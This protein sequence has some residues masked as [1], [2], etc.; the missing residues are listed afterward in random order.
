VGILFRA[1]LSAVAVAFLWSA[2]AVAA[3]PVKIK[4]PWAVTPAHLTPLLFHDK[5]KLKHN[6]KSYDVEVLFLRGSGENVTALAADEIQIAAVNFQTLH[7]LIHRA[8]LDVR[9]I[10]DVF[11]TRKGKA[12]G[13]FYVDGNKIKTI[14]D[15]KGKR[16]A[17]NARGS[18]VD[19]AARARLAQEGLKDGDDYTIVEMRFAAMLAALEAGRIDMAFLNLPFSLT[20]QKKGYKEMFNL[21]DVLGE[22][23][24]VMWVAKE[25]WLKANKAAVTDLLEDAVRQRRWFRDP[26]NRKEAL[27]ILAKVTKMPVEQYQEWAFTEFDYEHNRD[28]MPD[29]ALLQKNIDDLAK[30]GLVDKTFD[31]KPKVDLSYLEAALARLK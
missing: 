10:A 29:V 2:Q 24:T 20:A 17:V 14:A 9:V 30:T 12:G 28:A 21:V 13:E 11:Q 18:G 25:P 19:G 8:N 5:S 16:V 4:V 22:Q 26:A 7:N 31:V 27:E 1:C 15:L 3:D 6:G 23:Q